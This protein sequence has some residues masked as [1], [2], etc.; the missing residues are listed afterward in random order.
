MK[1]AVSTEDAVKHLFSLGAHLGHKKNR[2]H[3]KARKY[4][5]QIVNGVSIIDL[6]I[7]VDKL[8]KAKQFLNEAAKE[9]KTV[10]VV[11]TKKVTNQMVADICKAQ[12]IPYI[13][14]KWLP[15]LLTNFSTIIQNVK[16][17]QTLTDEKGRGEW[18]KFVKHERIQLDKQLRRLDRFYGGLLNL[19][20]KPDVILLVDSRKEKN[21]LNEAKMNTIP[22]V[23]VIDTNSD[24]DLVDFPILVNDDSPSV[25]DHIMQDLLKSYTDNRPTNS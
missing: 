11:A 10:L 25:L 7:T 17:L 15:G 21:A 20:K 19:V 22:V 14:T 12:G 3:P 23:G 8:A 6:T 24:P 2:L 4:I 18:D 1:S 9:N 5:Y 16:K 13:T